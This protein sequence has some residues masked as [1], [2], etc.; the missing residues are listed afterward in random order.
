MEWEGLEEILTVQSNVM[1][2]QDGRPVAPRDTLHGAVHLT[3]Q[4]L[5]IILLFEQSY[6]QVME[7]KFWY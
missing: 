3:K 4:S 6:G 5:H 2:R 7:R 1:E